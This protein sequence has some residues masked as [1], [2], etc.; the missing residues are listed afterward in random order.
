MNEI[1]L[2]EMMRSF[3]PNSL[4]EGSVVIVEF[5]PE[6][7]CE[8]CNETVHNH[9][10]CPICK[11]DCAPTDAYSDLGYYDDTVISCEIC[12]SKFAKVNID[13]DWYDDSLSMKIVKIGKIVNK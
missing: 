3:N 2:D 1:S 4:T 12:N 5:Y 8:M 11:K 6:I 9:F 13:D 7:C 10:D